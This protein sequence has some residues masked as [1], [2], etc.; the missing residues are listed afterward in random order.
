VTTAAAFMYHY[1]EGGG[2]K[3]EGKGSSR[4]GE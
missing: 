4:R 3:G 1:V 2:G